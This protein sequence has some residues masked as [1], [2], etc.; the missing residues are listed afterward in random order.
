M[1]TS[2]LYAVAGVL[3]LC[4]SLFAL[5]VRPQLLHKVLALNVA[6]SGVFLVY[7]A[8]ASRGGGEQLD[9][10]P[11]AMVITGIVIAVSTTALALVLV[12]KLE[13]LFGITRLSDTNKE[14]AE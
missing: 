8:L 5:A 3:V 1:T 11:Q 4:I 6:G 12:L 7:I 14:G 2:L 9:P 13:Q 10:V